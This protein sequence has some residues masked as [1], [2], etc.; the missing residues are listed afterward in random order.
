[1]SKGIADIITTLTEKLDILK[2][3]NPLDENFILKGALGSLDIVLKYLN[4]SNDEFILKGFFAY[5]TPGS[6]KFLLDG[7][8]KF[9]NPNGDEFIFNGLF[10]N[11]SNIFK[12]IGSIVDW[13]NPLSPNFF[14]YKLIE[15]FGN[16]LKNLFIPSQDSFNK[17][18]DTVYS[19]FTFVESI[20]IAINSIKDMVNNVT[21]APKLTFDVDTKIY[22]GKLTVLDLSFYKPYKPYGDLVFTGFMYVL[23]MYRLY[24]KL[25]SIINGGSS[26]LG[27]VFSKGDGE[28]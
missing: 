26:A 8:I 12:N 6:G 2:Y 3:L 25:P 11:I 18:K 5:L 4:P 19:K 1:M 14:V 16:L 22:K 10:D 24:T 28:E 17:L 15:L 7:I 20:K 9:F 13:L 27:N 23:Y 21:S